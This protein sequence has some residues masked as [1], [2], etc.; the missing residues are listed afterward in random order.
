MLKSLGTDY[1]TS[2]KAVA[3][4]LRSGTTSLNR[5]AQNGD[6]V[7]RFYPD[8]CNVVGHKTALSREFCMYGKTK[9][10]KAAATQSIEE[11]LIKEY[12]EQ[13]KKGKF[14]TYTQNFYYTTDVH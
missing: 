9:P 12:M 10:E 7:C 8:F 4:S 1:E 3:A 11:K 13:N 2:R 5:T 14:S 6:V